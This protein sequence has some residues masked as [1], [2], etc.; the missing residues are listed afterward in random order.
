MTQSAVFRRKFQSVMKQAFQNANLGM[1]IIEQQNFHIRADA[2]AC[3][4]Y[5]AGVG[6]QPGFFP[7]YQ[8]K[9]ICKGETA[10]VA[11]VY[12]RSDQNGV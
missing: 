3:R 2:A 9:T 6:N 12:F 4:F 10:G 11:L 5:I 1:R 8:N 7:R